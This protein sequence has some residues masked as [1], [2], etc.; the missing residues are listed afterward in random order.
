MKDKLEMF[1]NNKDIERRHKDRQRQDRQDKTKQEN[2][3]YDMSSF[4]KSKTKD[5]FD[6]KKHNNYGPVA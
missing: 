5:L 3:S 1:L 6:I 4:S 2:A